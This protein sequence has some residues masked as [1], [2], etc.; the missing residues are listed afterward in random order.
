MALSASYN[1][2]PWVWHG[3]VP[4]RYQAPIWHHHFFS[5]SYINTPTPFVVPRYY[6]NFCWAIFRAVRP[7]YGF[8]F[9]P[10]AHFP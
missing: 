6:H 9:A 10:R 5:A 2:S 4:L 8:S 7:G 1:R 3:K